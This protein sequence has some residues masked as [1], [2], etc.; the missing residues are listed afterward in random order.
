MWGGSAVWRALLRC[1]WGVRSEGLE[2]YSGVWGW[3]VW[4][5]ERSLMTAYIYSTTARLPLPV[6]T[7]P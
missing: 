6:S 1:E 5:E 3:M 4:E 7:T 2:E